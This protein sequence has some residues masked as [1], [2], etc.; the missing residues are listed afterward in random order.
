MKT[1]IYLIC[2]N[3]D[4]GCH[5][6]GIYDNEDYALTKFDECLAVWAKMKFLSQGEEI[7][8]EINTP[9]KMRNSG[10]RWHHFWL[11]ERD[12]NCD[13]EVDRHNEWQLVYIQRCLDEAK[14]EN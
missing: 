7:P 3:V 13:K 11:D 4:L 2:E 14:K 6:Y 10:G 12:L 8:E 9:E 1:K 5:V